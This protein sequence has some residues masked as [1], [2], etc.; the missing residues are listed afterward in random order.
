MGILGRINTV[1]KSNLNS[2]IDA[3]SDPAKEIELL[4]HDM[5]DGERRATE[6][7]VAAVAAAKRS[8]KRCDDLQEEVDRWQNRAMQAVRAGDDELAREALREKGQVERRLQEARAALQ[9]QEVF[10]EQL[11][12]SL[13]GLQQKIEDIKARKE[14]IKQKATASREGRDNLQEGQAFKDFDR[15]VGRIDALEAEVELSG[16]LDGR[17]AATEARFRE[18]ESRDP[19]VED[20]LAELKRKLDQ[21]D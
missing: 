21:G 5:Q 9:E 12:R 2:L 1:I 4:I 10:A 3:M 6:E 17:D 15:L 11:K 16:E 14:T 13:K 18:L 20:A 8:A 19:A 7:L